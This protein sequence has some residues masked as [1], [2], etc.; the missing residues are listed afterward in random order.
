M[1]TSQVKRVIVKDGKA[2][3]VELTSRTK[4][5]A[6]VIASSVDPQ[7][8]F[9]KFIEPEHLPEDLVSTVKMWPWEKTA[10]YGLHLSLK[11][12]PKYDVAKIEPAVNNSLW[13]VMELAITKYALVG[14]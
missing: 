12:P 11:E 1:E 3:G 8:N 4:I 10:L 5:E 7:Q 13:Q 14:V 9:L 2:T 6:K